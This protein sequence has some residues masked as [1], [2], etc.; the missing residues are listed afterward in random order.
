MN[1]EG[2][3]PRK[4]HFKAIFLLFLKV[5]LFSNAENRQ[6]TLVKIADGLTTGPPMVWTGLTRFTGLRNRMQA[7]AFMFAPHLLR[8]FALF[9]NIQQFPHLNW[10][11]LRAWPQE[12]PCQR[13]KNIPHRILIW[14]PSLQDNE[15]GHRIFLDFLK[16]AKDIRLLLCRA[17]L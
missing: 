17:L 4:L 1:F 15:G 16:T 10:S 5:F 2:Q 12:F 8:I 14:R 7:S 13:N 6:R 11:F 9:T 3:T